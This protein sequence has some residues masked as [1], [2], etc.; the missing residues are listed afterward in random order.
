MQYMKIRYGEPFSIPRRLGSE[1]FKEV[2]RIRGVN[3]VKGKG[4]IVSDY[5]ALSS[6]NHILIKLGL[7]LTP[8]VKCIVCGKNIDCESCKFKTVCKKNTK[9]CICDECLNRNDI[10]DKYINIQRERLNTIIKSLKRL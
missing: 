5:Y 9:V 4:F 3:Y 1:L 8:E 2:V 7:I 10:V 6:L